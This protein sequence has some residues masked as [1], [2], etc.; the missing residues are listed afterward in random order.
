VFP[1]PK[2]EGYR[3]QEMLAL[4]RDDQIEEI[5]PTSLGFQMDSNHYDLVVI[6]MT[7]RVEAAGAANSKTSGCRGS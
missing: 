1:T 5:I 6:G 4:R 7:R 3:R 2:A